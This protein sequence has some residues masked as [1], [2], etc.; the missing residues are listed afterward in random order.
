MT[1]F[2]YVEG[3]NIKSGPMNVYDRFKLILGTFGASQT[4][5]LQGRL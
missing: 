3:A 4:Y 1:V 5:P 2:T